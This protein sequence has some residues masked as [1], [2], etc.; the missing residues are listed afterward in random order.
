MQGLCWGLQVTL[1][2]VIQLQLLALAVQVHC[3]QLGLE[4]P[5][6]LSGQGS[7]FSVQLTVG[8]SFC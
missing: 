8:Q 4:V 2:I 5:G 1:G 7:A 3:P 6:E